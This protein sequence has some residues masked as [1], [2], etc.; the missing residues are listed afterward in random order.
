MIQ[1][2]YIAIFIG[3]FFFIK[4][5]IPDFGIEE[6]STL[7][8][9][10]MLLT[11]FLFSEIVKKIK[12]PRLSGYMLMGVILGTSG[13]GVLTED[14]IDGMQFLENLALSFIAL[15][16]GGELQF[17]QVK[18]YKKSLLYILTSQMAI[19]FLGMTVVFFLIAGYFQFFDDLN[20]YMILGFAI[21]FAGT[22]LSTS[23]ATAIGIITELQSEGK[24][25]NIVFIITVLK[26]LLLILFFPI[27]I[28]LSKQFYMETISFNLSLLTEISIRLLASVVTGIVMGGII[29]WYVKKVK[30][31]TSL[32]LLGITLAITEVSSLFGVEVLL[33]SLVTGI[34]VQNFSSHGRSLIQGI[35][36]FSLPIYVIFF[37][38]AGASLHLEI[39]GEALTITF[40]LIIARFLLNYA[41]NYVGAV[42]A[43]E[44]RFIKNYSWMGYIG[45]AGI[46]LGLGVIIEQNLPD[47]IGNYFLTIIISTVVINEML[48][49]VLLKYIFV[50]SGEAKV[51]D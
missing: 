40:V 34:V 12:L 35:E 21:L 28:T 49:P 5:L 19:I 24:V 9:G 45:Q 15:T 42:L 11:S 48:G 36:I 38:F 10:I 23:P 30:V 8:V 1:V 33:T 16:A 47:K 43:K 27:I 51:N 14:I 29:I 39:L 18:V 7:V 26:A 13:I 2:I 17:S 32:F 31:E 20:Q 25:T 50:K 4:I 46:A 37:C 22:S 3:I 41:G 6:V 44:D